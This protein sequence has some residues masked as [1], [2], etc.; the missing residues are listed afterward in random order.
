MGY[1][2][3]PCSGTHR[4]LAACRRQ[5]RMQAR[6]HHASSRA[7][8]LDNMQPLPFQLLTGADGAAAQAW[9]VS[10]AARRCGSRVEA[11][12]TIMDSAS[13]GGRPGA[14]SRRASSRSLLTRSNGSSCAGGGGGVARGDHE[15]VAHVCAMCA[16]MCAHVQHHDHGQ[17]HASCTHAHM[18]TCALPR[19]VPDRSLPP[20]G[21]ESPGH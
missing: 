5:M 8:Q 12:P 15:N 17:Y 6:K 18:G 16:C 10:H 1:A 21:L 9:V 4:R 13:S 2:S 20:P 19:L 11:A 14:S 7:G 3:V